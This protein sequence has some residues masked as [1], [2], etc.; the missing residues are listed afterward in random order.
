MIISAPA[1]MII[2]RLERGVRRARG[3]HGGHAGRAQGRCALAVDH[4]H[5]APQARGQVGG[6]GRVGGGELDRAVA[7]PVLAERSRARARGGEA[8]GRAVRGHATIVPW[9]IGFPT[10]ANG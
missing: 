1:L 9:E 4:L 6:G 8:A 7:C 3:E 10:R 2:A 5:V